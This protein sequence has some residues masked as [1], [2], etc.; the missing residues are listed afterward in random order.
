MKL[1]IKSLIVLLFSIASFSV[2]GQL[3][4]DSVKVDSVSCYGLNDGKVKIYISGGI[5]PYEV[6]LGGVV[7]IDSMTTSTVFEV[8]DLVSGNVAIAVYDDNGAGDPVFDFV[9]VKQ[10]Q[11]LKV[12]ISPAVNLLCDGSDYQLHGNPTGG[13]GV[14][15]HTWSG[16][17]SGM[18]SATDIENPVLTA[19]AG[20]YTLK[21]DVI[22][23]KGC[24]ASSSVTPVVNL[25]P[26][27]TFGGVLADQCA[28]NTTYTLSGGDPAGGSYSGLGVVGTNFD[29]SASG[30]PGTK[31][32]TYAY[33]DPATTCSNSATNTIEVLALPVVSISGTYP[34]QCVTSTTYALTGGT[35]AGGNYSGPGVTGTNFD[36]SVAGVGTHTITY[37]YTDPVAP[38]C[39]NTATKIITVEALPTVSI[40]Y[41]GTP[42]CK[43][44]STAQSVNLTGTGSYTGGTYSAL[45]TGL[46]INATT[47]AITP[48]TSTAG[49]Y[50]VTYITPASGPCGSVSTNTSVTITAVPV[51]TFS[52]A[53]TPYCS[54]ASNPL[55]TL[56]GSAGTFSALPA[57]LVFVSTATGE[58]NLATSTA[59]T[60][61][62]TNT[63]AAAG[64]CSVVTATSP[65]TITTLPTASISYAGTPFCKSVTTAQSVTLTGTGAYT[66][67]TYS[68]LP[69]GLTINT[70]TGAITPSTSTAG[71]Y[72]VTYATPASGGCGPVTATTSVTI[73][74]LPLATF[75]Y[76]GTPYCSNAS[77]PL[78]TL[79]GSA[80][81]FSALPAGLVFVSTAT[82]E[83]N[84]ATSTA[85]TYTVTNTIAAAGGCSVVT[86]TSPITI[87]TLP[88]ASISY[89]GTPFCKSVATAQSVTLTG[90]GAYTGGTYSAL[91]AGLTIN[92]TTGAI[93][94]STSTAGTYTVT[95]ATPASGGCGPVTATT[96]VTITALPVATFSYTGTPYCSNASNPLPSLS[97][98]AGTFSALPAGLVFVSTATGEVNLATSTAGTYTV[99]NT[100][101]AAGGC[102]VVT[103]TSPITITTL[104]TASISYAG[105]P[106][107]KSV[108]TAQS[109]TLTGTG[110]YTGGTYSAL[111]AGLTIN[112]TT[113]AITP[114]TSTAGTYTVTYA[115]PASGGCGP[116]TAT[117]SVTITALPVATF[118]YAGTPYCSNA[119]NPLPSL[120]GSAGTFSALPAGLVFV[121][122]AT[123]EVNLA[124]S[125]AGTY[126]VTNTIAAAGGCSLVTATSPITITT[127]PT[128]SISYAG[129]PFCKSVTTVQ[130]VT[131]T[132]TGA[133][134]GGTYSALPAGL[135]INTTTG[136]ITP[137]TSTAGT[138][139]VTYATPASGGCGPVTAT[140]SVTITA[141]P[142]ATF[143]YTGT[144]YCSNASNPLPTLSGSAG[145]FSALP[146]GLVFVSTATGEVNL[147]ASTIGTYTVTNTIAAA[148]GCSVVTATSPIVVNPLPTSNITGTTSIC[149]SNSASLSIALTGTAPWSLV[150]TDGTTPKTVT[151]ILTSPYVFSVSP[152]ST[153]T[154]TVTSLSDNNTCAATPAQMIGSATVTILVPP[155]A[156]ISGTGT[157]C[158]GGNAPLSIVLTGTAP[159]SVTYTDGTTPVTVNPIVSSP[160]NF[161]VNPSSTRT[162][163]L[164]AVSDASCIAEPSGLSGSATVTVNPRPTS[165]ISGS[166][167]ICQGSSATISVALTGTSSWDLTYSD[168]VNPPIP[169]TN[170]LTSPY[171]FSVSPAVSSTYTVTALSD[172]K[173]VSNASDRTGSA[174]ITVDPPTVGGTVS[175]SAT[176]CS[177]TNSTLLTLSGH[178]GSVVRW[179]YSANGGVTWVNIANTNTTYT[180][181][182]LSQTRQ[183]RA[184]V[185]SGSCLSVN[186][187]VATVTVVASSVGGTVGTSTSVCYGIN[188]TTLNLSGHTGSVVRWE[189]SINGGVTWLPIANITSSLTA[190]NLTQT[191]RYRAV[192][193]SGSCPTANSTAAIITVYSDLNAGTIGSD[194]NVCEN[195]VPTITET[196]ASGSTGVYTYL[197]QQSTDGGATWSNASGTNNLES[198]TAPAVTQNVQYK[199]QVTSGSCGTKESNVITVTMDAL[200]QFTL[201]PTDQS[202]CVG[203]NVTYIA[204]V[205]GAT[206]QKWQLS[207]NGGATF[208]D[209]PGETAN[210]LVV[211]A[212]TL[213]M[214]GYKYQLVATNACGNQTSNVVNLAVVAATTI[215]TQPSD[216][217]ICNN[218]DTAFTVVASGSGLTYSWEISTDG[219]TTYNPLVIAAPYSVANTATTSKLSLTA[220]PNTLD[221][222]MYR[223]QVTSATCGSTLSNAATLNFNNIESITLRTDNNRC[224]SGTVAL[225]ASASG[226]AQVLWYADLTGGTSLASGNNYTTPSISTTTT[227]YV[228]ADNNGCESSPRLPVVATI[229][230]LPLE[231]SI[232]DATVCQG[233]SVTLTLLNSENGV[234]YQ[235]RNN[236]DNSNIGAAVDGTGSDITF[237]FTSAS[238]LTANVLATNKTTSCLL[239][240]AD[241]ALI[242]VNSLPTQKALSN[243]TSI[244]AGGLAIVGLKASQNGVT[245]QL[246]QKSD[247]AVVSTKT[248]NGAYLQFD[249]V[250]PA[251]I[252]SYYV[253]AGNGCTVDMT[254]E[255]TVNVASALTISATVNDVTGCSNS[256][257]GQITVNVLT[258]TATSYTLTP[259]I[260]QPTNIFPGL[261]KGKYTVS[262]TNGVCVASIPATVGGPADIS[263]SI[264]PA[265]GSVCRKDKL[266]YSAT[267]TNAVAPVTYAWTS[268][269]GGF[270]DAASATPNYSNPVAGDYTINLSVTD[271][272]GCTALANTGVSVLACPTINLT[273]TPTSPTCF[274]YTNGKIDTSVT[275][276]TAPYIIT[277]VP[278]IA[279]LDNV[280][281]GSYTLTVTDA[282]LNTDDVTVVVDP[283]QKLAATMTVVNYD[284]TAGNGK[285]T[286]NA[287][288]GSGSYEYDFNNAGFVSSNVFSS[289]AAGAYSLKI[290][291]TKGCGEIDT[292]VDVL[293]DSKLLVLPPTPTDVRCYNT[294]T[295]SVRLQIKTGLAPFIVKL[296]RASFP[297][298]IL[299]F[300]GNVYSKDTTFEGLVKGSYQFIVTQKSPSQ[301]QSKNFSIADNNTSLLVIDSKTATPQTDLVPNGTITILASGG[302]GSMSSYSFSDDNAQTF[303]VNAGEFDGLVGNKKYYIAVQDLVGC[304]IHDSIVVPIDIKL[305]VDFSKTNET[306]TGLNDGTVTYNVTKGNGTYQYS[307][308]GAPFVPGPVTKTFTTLAPGIHPLLVTDGIDTASFSAN[309]LP[310]SAVIIDSI[311]TTPSAN[312][313]TGTMTVYVNP[314][315]GSGVFTF[316]ATSLHHG[317]FNT[318]NSS[319]VFTGLPA[320]TF[321]VS[322][323]DVCS[324]ATAI[325]IVKQDL[326]LKG[327][328]DSVEDV[329]CIQPVLIAYI[330]VSVSNAAAGSVYYKATNV[331]DPLNPN[332]QW[333]DGHIM[334]TDTGTYYIYVEDAEGKIYRDTAHVTAIVTPIVIDLTPSKLL[335]NTGE[336]GTIVSTVSGGKAPYK[337]EWY[338]NATLVSEEKDLV[339]FGPGKYR[340]QI[341]DSFG[342]NQVAVDSIFLNK[343]KIQKIV[344]TQSTC[345]VGITNGAIKVTATVVSGEPLR[346]EWSDGLPDAS[347]VTGLGAGVFTLKV[348]AASGCF[349]TA[350]IKLDSKNTLL[351]T[352][353]YADFT[354]QDSASIGFTIDKGTPAYKFIT[355]GVDTFNT[356]L[357]TYSRHIP[358]G[359]Y[360]FKLEDSKGCYDTLDY[361]VHPLPANDSVIID[362]V[363]TTKASGGKTGIIDV[364]AHAQTPLV[365]YLLDAS[366]VVL[367]S[368]GPDSIFKNLAAG[369]YKVKVTNISHCDSAI[370]VVVVEQDTVLKATVAYRDSVCVGAVVAITP[371][372]PYGDVTYHV[373]T[374]SVGFYIKDLGKGVFTVSHS[375]VYHI[376]AMDSE[377][378][379]FKLDT[380]INVTVPGLFAIAEKTNISCDPASKG[381]FKMT[382]GGGTIPYSYVWLNNATGDTLSKNETD[383]NNVG[384]GKYKFVLKDN[385]GCEFDYIDS[386]VF[387]PLIYTVKL[388][389][390]P[391]CITN[392][393]TSKNGTL[394]VTINSGVAPFI[395]Q[396]RDTVNKVLLQSD[397]TALLTDTLKSVRPSVYH[398]TIFD[399][400][401]CQKDTVFT[402]NAADTLDVTFDLTQATCAAYGQ[403]VLKSVKGAPKFK[404]VINDVELGSGLDN[405]DVTI[406]SL[407]QGFYNVT[408]EDG[409]GCQVKRVMSVNLTEPISFTSI[410]NN[411]TCTSLGGVSLMF[412]NTAYP[413]YASLN[414]STEPVSANEDELANF[415]DLDTGKYSLKIWNEIDG[416]EIDTSFSVLL[417]N[418]LQMVDTIFN[419]TCFEDGLI[420]V[421]VKNIDNPFF[422][423]WLNDTIKG[424]TSDTIFRSVKAG[425]YILEVI[426]STFGCS[427]IDTFNVIQ[428]DSLKVFAGLDT[429][430]CRGVEYL[431]EGRAFAG[432]KELTV[433][434]LNAVTFD[435]THDD[436]VKNFVNNNGH[437]PNPTIR[438]YIPNSYKLDS[439]Q[440]KLSVSY[441]SKCTNSDSV[442]ISYHQSNGVW[443]PAQDTASKGNYEIIPS[444]G[445]SGSF[446]SYMWLPHTYVVGGTDTARNLI[447]NFLGDSLTYQFM[448]ISA[449]GCVETASIRV[450]ATDD[451][452]PDGAF[453]PNGDGAN[454]FWYIPNA[455]YFPDI[456]VKIFNRWGNLVYE[457]KGYNNADVRWT[458]KRNGK[459]MPIG[460]YY[461]IITTS[462]SKTK[463]GTVTLMR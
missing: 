357:T 129:T 103:A 416:C 163:V 202:S 143:S 5:L 243:D 139:T 310:A 224:G 339:D 20:S 170:I 130:S 93:T 16:T 238:S 459:D 435:W 316:S 256:L 185:K 304:I 68:A 395:Y 167:N 419:Q 32:I 8:E 38:H 133:Y 341:V 313:T 278:A 98:S 386:L 375:G 457:S 299:V 448:G 152:S 405:I 227:Y 60:Y 342:C 137:S 289:I 37:T 184:V 56:S 410:I 153:K 276:G 35:P 187:G 351:S 442:V 367:T 132:G 151:N 123:G 175:G 140:T 13:N 29:A 79:S 91:P 372:N 197:W 348:S 349:D 246:K 80:G 138:Y 394:A 84:L 328:I 282:L 228:S 329:T 1:R 242:T 449:E 46:T 188:S 285:V 343:V 77:N 87:T 230:V 290:R 262:A 369:T 423:R 259:G 141:L 418:N 312:G 78:P 127:L 57:G 200:P 240:M 407:K 117:T 344:K 399:M 134:I 177:G 356:S 4:I 387:V 164:T 389:D 440:Y 270:D 54:N 284:G 331:N 206:S 261:A 406:P 263:L 201:Q 221:G 371:I 255:I 180:A 59:G 9:R 236:S 55:P 149:P 157:I 171:T 266:G 271:A 64:G 125:T 220:A 73:T 82:G 96:S 330:N 376:S 305:N 144:P 33:T 437:Q 165:V 204:T 318:V 361:I 455:E 179:Q 417:N 462:G 456:V 354:C 245:Y 414:E 441:G 350:T 215:S 353:H 247:N 402:V 292:T 362:T 190:T 252:A 359:A 146:A 428:G 111:P 205:T 248:G 277:A 124:T 322:V 383:L 28:N 45:P 19:V 199:R 23:Q 347:Y 74:A 436:Q 363:Y 232:N 447:V 75:S 211:N 311:A 223:C 463:K 108:T 115:T 323:V 145:T 297:K 158:N 116:V 424:T 274:G 209:I 273:A 173:C 307:F 69:A 397:T 390:S 327:K 385:A 338:Q 203:G 121:S 27:V 315:S 14:Y 279:D 161:N 18:L 193:Q 128:A 52:Y 377:T 454:E 446:V 291:D 166:V 300:S 50:T 148:G 398:L 11:K 216:A 404:Y 382:V 66:G 113:G 182:N 355:V 95:Y 391:S 303:D 393:D 373:T 249:A 443:L 229:N 136:A 131:L 156:S 192:V 142:V 186:S 22:D 97:G 49:T 365:Y 425:S 280:A 106:F 306:C 196:P 409:M 458:G 62:V 15:T 36:A 207:T 218:G 258:G 294:A 432:K 72:T 426:D 51:A 253:T 452:N 160:Y 321:N 302:T 154:Y 135:T 159:W 272:N 281:P 320:D 430:I 44:V 217:G 31:T 378:K 225:S 191:T 288:G 241:M 94:P 434:D 324:S 254:D 360:K 461:Y 194:Q 34:D 433:N 109:V 214:D 213:L 172:S 67:G 400:N 333:D 283:A 3:S 336:T 388:V 431:L 319:N 105:T 408:V 122:T 120:S 451:I 415:Q 237:S 326:V 317:A 110:A 314:N 267:I 183:Y 411:K 85:G 169:V 178:T 126:T 65:I 296:Y 337:Y 7:N 308:D 81:T 100:I 453:S 53:G 438:R 413:V 112:I 30:A 384:L 41:S 264:S 445:G 219:G 71:T 352:W 439:V 76:T 2:Y 392:S 208:S 309:I 244:C 298:A 17:A 210:S 444:I 181:T 90:T 39:V 403:L 235:L 168:G 380:L 88:T 226:T 6:I 346:Y 239:Q 421:K 429:T 250:S 379:R 233:G 176:V 24:T 222:N 26:S 265:N 42:F 269:S 358:E 40:S 47:G 107:C 61:T 70:T 368:N 104:P 251:S 102:S 370:K 450:I 63:I 366:D 295:G 119:S 396:W 99:T 92:T 48:S 25:L 43:S 420:K 345:N 21:Y 114:S 335:C 147:A 374:D 12:S 162:Y 275:G 301:T 364:R 198:Y 195:V 401:G 189:S 422:Y 287:T 460:T 325:A 101:A 412:S 332:E 58:V 86:A 155:T 89:A 260:T 174:V 427:K 118:S 293:D 231:K 10:P 334:V 381:A 83:V 150:Y 234:S 286:V 257:N 340:L 268:T 212:V